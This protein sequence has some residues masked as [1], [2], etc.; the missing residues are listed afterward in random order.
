MTLLRYVAESRFLEHV[1]GRHCR[2]F[3]FKKACAQ[4]RNALAARASAVI[5]PQSPACSASL[6]VNK[7]PPTHATFLQARNC[8]AL[9]CEMP[10]V[11]HNTTS[12]KGPAIAFSMPTPPAGTAGNSFNC[13]KPASRAV[14]ISDGVMVP[15]NNGRPLD[16]AA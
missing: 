7:E 12:L 2:P 3:A 14:M 6:G 13:R 11:G 9:S 1:M 15:G 16:L 4:A 10:P 8:A 5:L